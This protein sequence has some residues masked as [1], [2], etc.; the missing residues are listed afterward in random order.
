MGDGKN[1]EKKTEQFTYVEEV[2][3]SGNHIKILLL[4]ILSIQCN[5]FSV[6][7]VAFVISKNCSD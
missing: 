1:A 3:G 7:A 6:F 2:F 5:G 4:F